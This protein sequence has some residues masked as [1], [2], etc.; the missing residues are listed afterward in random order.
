MEI[1]FLLIVFVFLGI[2]SAIVFYGVCANNDFEPFAK[3][4]SLLISALGLF[5]TVWVFWQIG[6]ITGVIAR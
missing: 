4:L 1:L 3:V 2:P 6:E 5:I